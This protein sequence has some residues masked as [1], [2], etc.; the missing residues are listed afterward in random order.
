VTDKQTVSLV[1]EMMDDS[2]VVLVEPG[3]LWIKVDRAMY[4]K[5]MENLYPSMGEREDV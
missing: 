1:Y 5:V 4:D 2:E 3:S